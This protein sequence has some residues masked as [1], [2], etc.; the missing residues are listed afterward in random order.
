MRFDQLSTSQPNSPNNFQW[1][2]PLASMLL[3]QVASGQLLTS[4]VPIHT[5]DTD[6]LAFFIEDKIQVTPKLTLTLGVRYDYPTPIAIRQDTF[7]A[8]DL[9][10]ANPAAGGIPGAYRFGREADGLLQSKSEWA[11]RLAL[12][13]AI[14]DKTVLRLGYGVIYAQSNA[15]PTPLSWTVFSLRFSAPDGSSF[16]SGW[17]TDNRET[18]AGDAGCTSPP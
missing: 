10:L 12:G 13:Y 3:G 5:W 9:N 4:N 17:V 6:Y 16:R 14:N 11:P 1:G 15:G 8:I 7:S 18:S 2:D